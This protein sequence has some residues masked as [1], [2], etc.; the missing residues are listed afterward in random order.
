MPTQ[1]LPFV[2]RSTTV[3]VYI[4][5]DLLNKLFNFHFLE[6][7]VIY[8]DTSKIK[9]I[10]QKP[11]K[12]LRSVDA[13]HLVNPARPFGTEG[14]LRNFIS[15]ISKVVLP[16]RMKLLVYDA[17]PKKQDHI[18]EVAQTLEL[19]IQA[20]ERGSQDIYDAKPRQ[21]LNKAL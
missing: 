16:A 17:D 3:A 19:I 5:D 18:E 15:P 2:S 6:P 10:F 1:I 14:K 7:Y 21:I 13:V 4:L 8:S 11:K 12:E 9:K 20:L